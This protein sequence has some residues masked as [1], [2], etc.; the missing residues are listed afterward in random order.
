MRRG[1]LTSLPEESEA[2]SALPRS[3]VGPGEAV[4][5][6]PGQDEVQGKTDRWCTAA[7]S[8]RSRENGGGEAPALARATNFRKRNRAQGRSC[9]KWTRGKAR[10]AWRWWARDHSSRHHLD[11]RYGVSIE[12]QGKCHVCDFMISFDMLRPGSLLFALHNIPCSFSISTRAVL[13][14]A[15]GRSCED[16]QG[17]GRWR[18]PLRRRTVPERTGGELV[19]QATWRLH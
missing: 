3:V 10:A 14:H 17:S 11:A 16:L 8:A 15:R 7:C 9:G 18:S 1:T 5:H 2:R 4:C 19:R 6:S 12:C 13:E